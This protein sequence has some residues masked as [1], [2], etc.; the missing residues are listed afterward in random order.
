MNGQLSRTSCRC[1][2]FLKA[3]S[4]VRNR[5]TD[6]LDYPRGNLTAAFHKEFHSLKGQ[7]FEMCYIVFIKNGGRK[8]WFHRLSIKLY[9]L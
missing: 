5:L 9:L 3:F 4:F 7:D 2:P 8:T 1:R 6:I